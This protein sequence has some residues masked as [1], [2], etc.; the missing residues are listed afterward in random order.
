M[1]ADR[2]IAGEALAYLFED[3]GPGWERTIVKTRYG[4][5]YEGGAWACFPFSDDSSHDELWCACDND[6]AEWW[7]TMRMLNIPIG[8][9]DTPDLALA[10]CEAKVAAW[11]ASHVRRLALPSRRG[12]RIRAYP[13]Q[14]RA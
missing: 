12:S 2:R 13:W 4:G 11:N 8:V 5:C 9:G 3:S 10:D 14:A 6:C 1:P 7:H